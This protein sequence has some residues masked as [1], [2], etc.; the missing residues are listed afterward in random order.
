MVLLTHARYLA[1]L[2]VFAI[3]PGCG[4]FEFAD[5]H[6]TA[7]V[8][9]PAPGA[10]IPDDDVIVGLDD[11][12]EIT[13]DCTVMSV[14]VEIEIEHDWSQDLTID[15]TG[16]DGTVVRLLAATD[17]GDGERDLFETFPGTLDAVGDLTD[18]AGSEGRGN[19]T[20]RIEDDGEGDTGR[21]VAWLLRLG[22]DR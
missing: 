11:T 13:D 5:R 7:S 2:A 10:E 6:V 20:L 22:C 16:P 12:L 21:L 15:L 17:D 19:W 14:E 3:A 4:D 1:V 18:F 8:E 9:H